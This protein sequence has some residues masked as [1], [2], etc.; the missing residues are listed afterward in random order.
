MIPENFGEQARDGA[1]GLVLPRLMSTWAELE[2]SELLRQKGVGVP[3]LAKAW[4]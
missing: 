1:G 2:K 3:A 4:P